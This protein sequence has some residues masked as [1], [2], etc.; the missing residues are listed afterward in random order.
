M[1]GEKETKINRE[2]DIKSKLV[3]TRK[4]IRNK[5]KKAYK[6]RVSRERELDKTFT[7][8]TNA[9]KE[10]AKKPR[11]SPDRPVISDKN[12]SNYGS[13]SEM[14]WAES[15][16]QMGKT[17]EE[18]E[19]WEENPYYDSTSRDI[20][21]DDIDAAGPS[22]IGGTSKRPRS[23]DDEI[24]AALSSQLDDD[25]ETLVTPTAQGKKSR[26]SKSDRDKAREKAAKITN[27]KIIQMRNVN[28]IMMNVQEKNRDAADEKLK[29]YYVISSNNDDNSD[30]EIDENDSIISISD[31]DQLIAAGLHPPEKR[32]K[33]PEGSDKF[34]RVPVTSLKHKL[35]GR[36]SKSELLN[37]NHRV[38]H[39]SRCNPTKK[40]EVEIIKPLPAISN[41][42]L[43]QE[44][45]TKRAKK[46]SVESQLAAAASEAAGIQAKA[47]KKKGVKEQKKSGKGIETDFI[48]YNEHVAYEFY[49]DPNEL[50]E[51]LRI[52]IASRAAGNSNH[53]QEINS[54]V[55]ELRESAIIK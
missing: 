3:K 14:D 52:L 13:D 18:S 30:H 47:K 32:S 22:N 5:F 1:C 48:P 35:S 41:P 50:C 12:A 6:D 26:R 2:K 49:D 44:E 28:K 45:K 46:G 4:V 55:A 29:H 11:D 25:D 42:Y 9:I 15:Q 7:P 10:L 23:E 38:A 53:S 31:D 36:Y 33:Q 39:K 8:I 27:K 20:N 17:H 37:L 16:E 24:T 51:R 54:I 19:W 21:L 43:T 40:I 34:I